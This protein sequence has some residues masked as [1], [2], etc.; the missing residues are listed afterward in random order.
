VIIQAL[1]ASGQL[2]EATPRAERF[3]KSHPKSVLL[4]AVDAAVPPGRTP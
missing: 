3:R 1:A 4:P 2:G